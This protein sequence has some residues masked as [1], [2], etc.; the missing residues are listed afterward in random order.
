MSAIKVPIALFTGGHDWLAD[1]QDV[2][3]LLPKLEQT[4]KVIYHK[5]IDYY[6]HL[7]FLWGMDAATV[8]YKNV[9]ELA[10]K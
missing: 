3:N 4:G 5:N 7:D 8:V 10:R 6:N 9:I 1:P 2:A